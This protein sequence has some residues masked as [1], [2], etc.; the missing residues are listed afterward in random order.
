MAAEGDRTR[1]ILAMAVARASRDAGF[2][3]KLVSSPTTTLKAEGLTIEKGV[4][5][6]VLVDTKPVKYVALGR[7]F[8]V[9]PQH[10]AQLTAVL[11]R[12]V[13]IPDGSE[14]R[15]VQSTDTVRYL[16]VPMLPKDVKPGE[17][18]DEELMQVTG[19]WGHHNSGVQTVKY[20]TTEAVAAE[21]TEAAVT[22]TT[23]AQDAETTTTAAAEAEVVAVAAAVLT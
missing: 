17:L 1:A 5:W 23:E 13:P 7:D 21:T 8:R 15:I 20:A 19:G 9:D 12:V 4:K 11:S 18:S 10:A 3:K 16:V 6:K 2:R 22:Q 14:L